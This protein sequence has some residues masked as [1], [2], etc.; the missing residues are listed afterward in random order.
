[1]R[2]TLW[3]IPTAMVAV[4][5]ALFAITYGLDRAAEAGRF[6]LPGFITSGSPDA[7]RQIL[8]AIAA[9]II[10]VAGVLFSITILVLQLASQQFGPRMLRNFIRDLGTQLS[11]GAFVAT[12]VYSVLALGA[13]ESAPAHDFVP[14][15]SV[16][17]AL[18]LTLVDLAITIYFIHHVATS[19]QLTS[20]ISGIARDFRT[21]LRNAQDDV[22]RAQPPAPARG[23]DPAELSDLVCSSGAPVFAHDSGFIQ[24]VGHRHL[25]AIAVRSDTVIRLVRRPGHFVVQGQPVAF[26]LPGDAVGAVAEA[27]RDAHIIGSNR[28]LTQDVGFAVDQLAEVAIRAL[29][30]AVN[31]TF[32]ALNCIDWLGDCLCQAAVSPLPDG[33]HRDPAGNVR[34]IEPVITL[35]RLV[36]GATDKIRQAASGMPA[37]LI[38]QLDN[39]GKVRRAVRTAAQREMVESHAR[40]VLRAAD[41]TVRDAADRADIHDAFALAMSPVDLG[42]AASDSWEAEPSAR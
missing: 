6:S 23:P 24:S 1:M 36:K 19:I 9:A 17:V 7:A 3:I 20:V 11:L 14:H 22:A 32:T 13:V 42:V 30:P 39:L 25:M 4:A 41:E 18:T 35:D 34:I 21:T 2:T 28:T 33:V 27:L 40:L 37:V 8:I 12:F 29:S 15:I 38:R 5:G 16:T 26:V 10:T 31:D